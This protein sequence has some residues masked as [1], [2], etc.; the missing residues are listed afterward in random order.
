M[1]K[2]E[3]IEKKIFEMRQALYSIIDEKNNLLDIDVIVASQELDEV[4]NEYSMLLRYE[5]QS[6]LLN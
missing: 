5:E 1:G 2:I 6:M 4:L 3:K